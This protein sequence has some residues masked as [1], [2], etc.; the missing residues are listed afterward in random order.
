MERITHCQVEDSFE[1]AYLEWFFLVD[2]EVVQR[3][4]AI[5]CIF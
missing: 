3:L 4:N 2:I 1:G 5:V